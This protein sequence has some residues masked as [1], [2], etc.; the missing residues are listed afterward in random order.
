[1]IVTHN[2]AIQ[3]MVN[4]VI[5]IKDGKIHHEY[6]NPTP[7]FPPPAWNGKGGKTM[8][9]LLLRRTLRDLKANIFRYLTL[10]LFVFLCMFIVVG[11]VGSAESVIQTVHEKA[12]LNSL[13]DGQF[14][15]SALY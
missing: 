10:F 8:Q 14:G 2:D 1:M 6:E 13:E 4:K 9:K 3:G 12:R 7:L 15:V 11:V 5:K